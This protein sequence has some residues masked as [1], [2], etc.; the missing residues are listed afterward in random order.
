MDYLSDVHNEWL[1][2]PVLI[3]GALMLLGGWVAG[4]KGRATGEGMLLTLFLGPL[5]LLLEALLPTL[6]VPLD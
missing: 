5:G 6:K 4:C 3:W 2:A 1:L